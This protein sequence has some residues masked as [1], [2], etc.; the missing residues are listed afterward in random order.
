MLLL[1]LALVMTA[2]QLFVAA[3]SLSEGGSCSAIKDIIADHNRE[4]PAAAKGDFLVLIVI[5]VAV[6]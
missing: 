3:R 4:V 1:L 5:W 6:N 2:N